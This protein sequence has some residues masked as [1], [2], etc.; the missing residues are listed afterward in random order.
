MYEFRCHITISLNSRLKL[1]ERILKITDNLSKTLQKKSM[2]VAEAQTLAEMTIKTLTAMRK[3][4]AFHLFF[5][6]VNQDCDRFGTF[7]PS[8]P[9][10]K[11]LKRFEVGEG[12]GYACPTVKDHFRQQ[13]FEV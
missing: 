5:E 8:L 11:A 13:Y 10:R 9:R 7:Q 2:S 3:D 6:V 1:C 4:Q 12:D